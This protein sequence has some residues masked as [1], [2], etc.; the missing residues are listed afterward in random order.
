MRQPALVYVSKIYDTELNP[1]TCMSYNDLKE[2]LKS[3]VLS[4]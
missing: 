4:N 2:S 3:K 1:H